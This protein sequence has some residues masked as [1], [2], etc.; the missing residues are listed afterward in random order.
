LINLTSNAIKFTPQ[1]GQ[2]KIEATEGPN[3]IELSIHDT[4]V[5]IPQDSI[6]KLFNKFEQVKSNQGQNRA[7]KGTGLGLAIVKGIIEAHGGK[8]WIKSPAPWGKGSA[9]YFTI[10]KLTPELKAKLGA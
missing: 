8:I 7:T 9:F 1:D 2:I 10:P 6:G 4:G 3:Y 5:G